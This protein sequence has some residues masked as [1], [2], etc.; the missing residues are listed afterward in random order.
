M[1]KKMYNEEFKQAFIETLPSE[2][3]K[4]KTRTVFYAT[5]A[6]EM[7]KDKDV[8]DF[9]KQE[10]TTLFESCNW[11]NKNYF[12]KNLQIFDCHSEIITLKCFNNIIYN[13]IILSF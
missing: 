4:T 3:L 13:H 5:Y 6:M 12:N 11:T 10:F 8:F 9:N 2:L 7:K 1:S